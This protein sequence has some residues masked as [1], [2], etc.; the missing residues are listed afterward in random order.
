[1]NEEEIVGPTLTLKDT[2][3]E[4]DPVL[5]GEGVGMYGRGG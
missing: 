1:V 3:I 2:D 5:E 4:K